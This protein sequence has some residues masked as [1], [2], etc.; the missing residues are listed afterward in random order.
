MKSMRS[1]CLKNERWKT[2]CHLH[3]RAGKKTY[4]E[5]TPKIFPWSP[6]WK[7]VVEEENEKMSRWFNNQIQFDHHYAET[8]VLLSVSKPL[9][10]NKVI[11]MRKTKNSRKDQDD[12][13]VGHI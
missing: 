10:D 8:P 11:H 13:E 1:K 9:H 12:Q 3:F 5:D 7:D 2:I 6:E 4:D